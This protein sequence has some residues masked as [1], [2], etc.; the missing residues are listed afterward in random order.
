MNNLFEGRLDIEEDVELFYQFYKNSDDYPW[1]IV[2]H[3]V[4]EHSRR[5]HFLQEIFSKNY[6]VFL[7]DLRGHGTS[8]GTKG[9]VDSFETYAKDLESVIE[10]TKNYHSMKNYV[11]YSHSMGAL[12]T[13]RFLQNFPELL[14]KPEKVFLSAPPFRPGGVLGELTNYLPYKLFSSLGSFK[15]GPWIKDL[16]PETALTNH[17]HGEIGY[18]TD[19]LVLGGMQLRLLANLVKSGKDASKIALNKD[20][21]IYCVVGEKDVVV[22]KKAIEQY[23]MDIDSSVHLKVFSDGKHEL[24]NEI[25]Q[26]RDPYL[27]YLKDCLS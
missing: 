14:L 8:T 10:F 7:Y 27:K 5:Y 2:T 25:D 26:I 21:N 6:N 13:L 15:K 18:K 12:I 22:S 19:P 16:I 24:H 9:D 1:L 23:C 17:D 11:L 20:Y 4:G 3:G